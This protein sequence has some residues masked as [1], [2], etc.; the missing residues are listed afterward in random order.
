MSAL[1][2][3]VAGDQVKLAP[4]SGTEPKVMDVEAARINSAAQRP[5][6]SGAKLDSPELRRLSGLTLIAL[7]SETIYAVTDYWLNN[8]QLNYALSSGTEQN[9]DLREIDWG[10]TMRLNAERGVPITLR[11]GRHAD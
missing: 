11:S 10:K 7:K 3:R 2:S 4:V 1:R 9:V 5:V 6:P 8:G